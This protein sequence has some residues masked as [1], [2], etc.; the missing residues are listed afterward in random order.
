MRTSEAISHFGSQHKLARALGIKQGSVGK[1]REFPP[2]V[3]QIQLERLTNGALR[4][5][6]EYVISGRRLR[7]S[8][9]KAEA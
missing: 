8:A 2:P 4:A 3:R 7:P 9:T 6:D 1:W 5:Q